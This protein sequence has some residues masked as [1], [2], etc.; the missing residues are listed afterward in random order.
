[1][2]TSVV[3]VLVL[4]LSFNN[5]SLRELCPQTHTGTLTLDPAG[6]FR[7][8][9]PHHF[10]NFTGA[11]A[12]YHRWQTDWATYR[13][14]RT[15]NHTRWRVGNLAAV[16]FY[17]YTAS[18]RSELIAIC[19]P[20]NYKWCRRAI[21]ACFIACPAAMHRQDK[22]WSSYTVY[23]PTWRLIFHVWAILSQ[24]SSMNAHVQ[25]IYWKRF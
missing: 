14:G 16:T 12:R 13:N 17:L 11:H 5:V 22:R 4:N 20:V 10:L 3:T 2:Y 6:N 9:D 23:M 25:M 1:M 24:S 19:R 8:P 21:T 7:L 15:L 18:Q